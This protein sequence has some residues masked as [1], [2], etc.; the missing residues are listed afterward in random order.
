MC[1][2]CSAWTREVEEYSDRLL[3]LKEVPVIFLDHLAEQRKRVYI[4]APISTAVVATNG[5]ES[6]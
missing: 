6:A 3:G 4:I 2:F 5:R 1:R